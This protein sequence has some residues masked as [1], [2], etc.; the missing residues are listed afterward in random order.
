MVTKPAI[1]WLNTDKD[2]L[3]INNASVVLTGVAANADIYKN[4][5]PSIAVIQTALD[6]FSASVIAARDGGPSATAAKNNLRLVLVS[7]LRELSYFVAGACQGS[8]EKLI[9]SG[10]PPQKPV[11][12]P[13]GPLA[14]PHNPTLTH[15]PSSG[16][17]IAKANP[18]F[19]A[20]TY[21]WRLTPGTAGTAPIIAQTT[22]ANNTFTGLTP[23]VN[24]TMTVS[25]VGAAGPSGWSNAAS[26]FAD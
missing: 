24:Y 13:V 1:R 11:R 8:M 26:L 14:A 12:Q 23:G 6:N 9:L 18:V 19:G 16:A 2:P 10:F 3:L 5:T 21:T 20:S 7:L 4:P 17:L 22:A 25:G 15:G